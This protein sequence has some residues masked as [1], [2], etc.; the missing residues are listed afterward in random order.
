MEMDFVYIMKCVLNTGGG[1]YRE[2]SWLLVLLFQY[3]WPQIRYSLQ[4][5]LEIRVVAIRYEHQQYL[6]RYSVEI[7]IITYRF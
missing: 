3:Y 2:K 1:K 6:K 4:I 7:K 5:I